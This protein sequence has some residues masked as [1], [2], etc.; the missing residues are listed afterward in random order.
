MR[1]VP[2]VVFGPGFVEQAHTADEWIA[3]RPAVSGDGNSRSVLPGVRRGS[4]SGEVWHALSVA[5]GVIQPAATPF[6]PQG[7]P[8]K[9][10]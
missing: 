4:L 6:V 8:P 5:K 2:S 7:V 10:R 9:F 1:G 3:H